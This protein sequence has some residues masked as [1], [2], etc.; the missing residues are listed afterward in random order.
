MSTQTIDYQQ[1][2]YQRLV[3]CIPYL[4]DSDAGVIKS[5]TEL[6]RQAHAPDLIYYKAIVSNTAIFNG[7]DNV[8]STAGTSL[9]RHKAIAKAVG[10]AIERYAA[11]SYSY[12]QFV[13]S[14]Y[15]DLQEKALNPREFS[16]FLPS[17]YEYSEFT[18]HKFSTQSLLNWT[19]AKY[20]NNNDEVW[21]PASMVYCPF[22]VQEA[23]NESVIF[24]AMST[25][26]AAHCSYEE[27]AINGI[28]EIVERNNFMFNW[29]TQEK[30]RML[31]KSSLNLEHH[32]LI[33]IY[34]RCGYE[35]YL[36]YNPGEDGIPSFIGVMKGQRKY[37]V[38]FLIAAATHLDPA[39]AITKCLEE[40][41]LMERFC[42]RS[43]LS[44]SG[45]SVNA[46]F[47]RITNLNDHIKL[48]FSPDM[49]PYSDFLLS[50]EAPI[51]LKE[52]HNWSTCHP[53]K[54]LDYLIG[55]IGSLG[56]RTII[57]DISPGDIA[58]LGLH[59]VRAI[60]PGYIPL[61][62]AYVHRTLGTKYLIDYYINKNVS[63]S[64]IHNLVN[65]IP[66]P[67]G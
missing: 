4:V 67:F 57:A 24:E 41:A 52:I 20:A 33:D 43:M 28:L 13:F 3:D 10:E 55:A 64:E 65:P 50:N 36:S 31:D 25:G 14:T 47:N 16:M 11:G 62:K 21:V 38:P 49:W 15:D 17:Q 9:N 26:L 18:L 45:L 27:A 2:E 30:P 63:P 6:P 37:N 35:I 61:N 51:T 34:S 23:K 12:D 1:F 53:E 48:W 19:K 5:I 40:L 46:D 39:Q 8:G 60:V 22:S 54:D 59:V 7:H 58:D 56:Y 44:S 29:L 32:Q 66:H 42:H